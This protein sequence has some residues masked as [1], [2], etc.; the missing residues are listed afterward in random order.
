M[1]RATWREWFAIVSTVE[2]IQ[3]AKAANSNL[4]MLIQSEKR[5]DL[6]VQKLDQVALRVGREALGE[7]VHDRIER[8]VGDRLALVTATPERERGCPIARELS[9]PPL[10][11][12]YAAL[13]HHLHD[14]RV[15]VLCRG[16][17]GG[18]GRVASLGGLREER[19]LP[20]VAVRR[21]GDCGVHRDC[22]FDVALCAQLRG[23]LRV[24][25]RLRRLRRHRRRDRRPRW[26]GDAG[27]IGRVAGGDSHRRDTQHDRK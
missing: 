25:R 2:K 11:E 7:G 27:T 21:F 1:A 8:L 4:G 13:A 22:G 15:H 18:L 10:C 3:G 9:R 12:V 5:A 19:L 6:V 20:H 23:E 24:R 26:L 14:L 16:G 17:A